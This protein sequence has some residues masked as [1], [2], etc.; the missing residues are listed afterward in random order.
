[1]IEYCRSAEDVACRY[2][3]DEKVAVVTYFRRLCTAGET[4][5]REHRR[6]RRALEGPPYFIFSFKI[7][8]L[9]FQEFVDKHNS[10][11]V[12]VKRDLN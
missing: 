10:G 8:L 1:M 4:C 7:T 2:G 11:T 5:S 6:R 3:N 9:I 12:Y